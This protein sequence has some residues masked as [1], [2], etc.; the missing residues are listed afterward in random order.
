VQLL[1]YHVAH[2]IV[3]TLLGFLFLGGSISRSLILLFMQPMRHP[4]P[5][6]IRYLPFTE[7]L[8]IASTV[9]LINALKKQMAERGAN[10][11]GIGEP[12]EVLVVGDRVD[13]TTATK[14]RHVPIRMLIFTR[15]RET[16]VA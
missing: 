14:V 15:K 11:M 9:T 6:L 16:S 1:A 2:V 7:V 10:D 12:S 5:I 4:L 13:Q 8:L 3:L